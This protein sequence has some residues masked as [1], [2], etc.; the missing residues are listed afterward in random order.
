MVFKGFVEDKQ[1]HASTSF[2]D[3]FG[4]RYTRADLED[5][6]RPGHLKPALTP[7]EPQVWTA[8][9]HFGLLTPSGKQMRYVE[10]QPDPREP[11]AAEAPTKLRQELEAAQQEF[12]TLNAA[13]QLAVDELGRAEA[14]IEEVTTLAYERRIGEAEAR[15]R[16]MEFEGARVTAS[17]RL[18]E[19][20]G[21]R[22]PPVRVRLSEAQKRLRWWLDDERL[23]RLGRA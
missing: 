6:A 2:E 16:L 1:Q 9:A 22:S 18:R 5:P 23:R 21:F 7:I 12:D 10:T 3:A 4:K 17:E 11:L 19:L 14:G 8:A 13:R 20:D 15:Q